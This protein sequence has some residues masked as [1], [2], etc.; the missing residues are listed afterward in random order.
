MRTMEFKTVFVSANK[1]CDCFFY[2]IQ[3]LDV[4][5]AKKVSYSA[6]LNMK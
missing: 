2:V 5:L 4:Y 6:K 1:C 3:I